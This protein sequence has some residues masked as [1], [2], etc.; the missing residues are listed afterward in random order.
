[1]RVNLYTTS[2]YL[3]LRQRVKFSVLF[4]F[5]PNHGY[6]Y[7]ECEHNI[8]LLIF[9]IVLSVLTIITAIHHGLC[10]VELSSASIETRVIITYDE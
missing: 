8:I 7:N 2:E 3:I 1:V 10:I 6:D 9:E 4:Y 5:S